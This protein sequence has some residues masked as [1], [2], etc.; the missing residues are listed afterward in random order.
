MARKTQRDVVLAYMLERG[1]QGIT[2]AECYRIGGGTRL[3]AIV[4]SMRRDGYNVMAELLDVEN[5]LGGRS[6]PARYW[7]LPP[8]KGTGPQ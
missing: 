3:A 7:M 1:R 6:H 2:Q 8:I 5:S 4:Y